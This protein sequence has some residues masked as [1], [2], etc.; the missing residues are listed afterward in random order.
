MLYEVALETGCRLQEESPVYERITPQMQMEVGYG[1]ADKAM[2]DIVGRCF[3]AQGKTTATAID[4]S[5]TLLFASGI[6]HIPT[7]LC[8]LQHALRNEL[9]ADYVNK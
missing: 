8:H 1:E 9:P 6:L 4:V 2:S 7:E 3:D 5:D